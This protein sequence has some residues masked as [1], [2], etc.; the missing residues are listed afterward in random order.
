MSKHVAFVSETVLWRLIPHR[1]TTI[2]GE[3]TVKSKAYT[4][5]I[6]PLF[7]KWIGFPYIVIWVCSKFNSKNN[8]YKHQY[9][10]CLFSLYK[11]FIKWSNKP[12]ASSLSMKSGHHFSVDSESICISCKIGVNWNWSLYGN[13]RN[14]FVC[15]KSPFTYHLLSQTSSILIW[16]ESFVLSSISDSDGILF[17]LFV[18]VLVFMSFA[19]ISYILFDRLFTTR[20]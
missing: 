4:E 17:L 19:N 1:R 14:Q 8:G 10:C 9:N 3:A 20:R 5:Q 11:P 18:N 13:I 16:F 12:L 15:L 2:E 6:P 7:T